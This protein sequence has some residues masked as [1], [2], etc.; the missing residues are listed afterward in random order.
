M[1]I[2]GLLLGGFMVSA[3]VSTAFF[4]HP[5]SPAYAL[6]PASTA[7]RVFIGLA[8]GVTAAAL[9]Y[10]PPGQRS[11]AHMNPAVTLAFARLGK[12]PPE[13]AAGYVASQFI[14]AFLG[15]GVAAVLLG[16]A[17]GANEVHFVVTQPGPLGAAAAFAAE[18]GI[19]F[20][21]MAVVLFSSSSKQWSRW[22]GLL[23][24]GLVAAYIALEA[25]LSGMS[26][27][28][29]RTLGS[30]LWAGEF[31]GLWL[32]FTAPPIGM[33]LAAELFVRQGGARR[34]LCAKLFHGTA[35]C[36]L[37]GQGLPAVAPR[38]SHAQ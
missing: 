14:G 21:L 34:A 36:R 20:V 19:S 27:N 38:R 11:G 22:T 24:A 30:A 18:M 29:A 5:A 6:F 26:M 37:C 23:A 12:L 1:A 13:D 9:I 28:P 3:A 15:L 25:P 16:P 8:M 35:P 10:S 2:D 17:L 33:L 7:R 32:Y 31:R 4:E